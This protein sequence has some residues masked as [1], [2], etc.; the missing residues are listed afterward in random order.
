MCCLIVCE[1]KHFQLF[2]SHF[3]WKQTPVYIIQG[4]CDII[5]TLQCILAEEVFTLSINFTHAYI[6]SRVA[7][8]RIV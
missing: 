8:C 5:H 1:I 2:R 3:Y 7:Y 4:G 6:L